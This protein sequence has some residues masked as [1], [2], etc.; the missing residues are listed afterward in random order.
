M[1]ASR[2][3]TVDVSVATI[4]CQYPGG[5]VSPQVNKFEQ[6]SSEDH[7]MPVAEG[8]GRSHAWYPEG[9]GRIQWRIQ[10]GAPGACPLYG[11]KFS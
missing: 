4:R 10:R 11:P 6:V 3:R 2:L 7:K 8:G 1:R 9:G 5:M